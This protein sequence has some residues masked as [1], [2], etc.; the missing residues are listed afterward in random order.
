MM[1]NVLK[2][3]KYISKK[4]AQT[5]RIVAIDDPTHIRRA[6]PTD[7]YPQLTVDFM[8]RV[9][10]SSAS[11]V[12]S[13]D[14]WQCSRFTMTTLHSGPVSVVDDASPAISLATGS[15]Q[16]DIRRSPVGRLKRHK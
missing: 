10:G 15:T 7:F 13:V 9:S 6:Q 11:I 14:R 16:K 5:V 1:L 8:L 3:R 4:N 12:W 2:N